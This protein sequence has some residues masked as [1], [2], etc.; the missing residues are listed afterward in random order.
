VLDQ[1][2]HQGNPLDALGL[3]KA[4]E[5]L[6]RLNDEAFVNQIGNRSTMR[7]RHMNR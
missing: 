7:P 6:T 2:N 4:E 3:V 5:I 1:K